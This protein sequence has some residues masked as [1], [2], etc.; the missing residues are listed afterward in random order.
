MNFNVYIDDCRKGLDSAIVH[1]ALL[2][3]RLVGLRGKF[4]AIGTREE[5]ELFLSE[6]R[7]ETL[8]LDL[9]TKALAVTL[10]DAWKAAREASDAFRGVRHES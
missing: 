4:T 10:S 9:N 6:I 3:R 7:N 5:A 8:M 2:Q 1:V